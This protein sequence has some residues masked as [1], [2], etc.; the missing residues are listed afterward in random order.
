VTGAGER[1]DGV[2][3]DIS[4]ALETDVVPAAVAL[5]GRLLVG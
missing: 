2:A 5:S 1:A 3:Q 4:E